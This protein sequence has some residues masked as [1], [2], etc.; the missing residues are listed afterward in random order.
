MHA[1]D[2]VLSKN[3]NLKKQMRKNKL[4]DVQN[5]KTHCQTE[6]KHIIFYV[7]YFLLI[8]YIFIKIWTVRSRFNDHGRIDLRKY[9]KHFDH[10]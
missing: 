9:V 6:I 1:M 4:E 7:W 8:K 5:V 3:G 10:E 2:D